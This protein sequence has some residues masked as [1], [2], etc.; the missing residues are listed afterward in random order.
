MLIWVQAMLNARP[1]SAVDFVRPVIACLESVYGAECGRGT[2]AEMDPLL[3]IRPSEVCHDQ[4]CAKSCD[5]TSE[6]SVWH[7]GTSWW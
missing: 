2:C 7:I 3:M 1:S 4:Q 5:D 6:E